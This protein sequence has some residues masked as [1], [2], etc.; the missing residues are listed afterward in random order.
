MYGFGG[1]DP[2]VSVDGRSKRI[3]KYRDS[4]ESALEWTGPKIQLVVIVF[5]SYLDRSVDN[6]I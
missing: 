2:R 5:I 6:A 1:S 4:N 3:K